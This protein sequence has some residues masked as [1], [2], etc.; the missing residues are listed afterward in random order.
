MKLFATALIGLLVS[1]MA[2]AQSHFDVLKDKYLNQT[3]NT[4]TAQAILGATLGR[5]FQAANDIPVGMILAAEGVSTTQNPDEGPLFPPS[6][7]TSYKMAFMLVGN[8]TDNAGVLSDDQPASANDTQNAAD[9]LSNLST[10]AVTDLSVVNGLATSSV[11]GTTAIY[12]VKMGNDGLIY[13]HATENDPNAAF[14]T[15]CYFYKKM[16]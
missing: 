11:V 10:T 13:G 16:N 2:F 6:S 5:C 1:T 14:E 15:Y 4:L 8:I 12:E 9:V 7:T 3:N